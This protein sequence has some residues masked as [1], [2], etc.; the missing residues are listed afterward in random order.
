[1]SPKRKKSEEVLGKGR[2]CTINKHHK[3]NKYLGV[4]LSKD[5]DQG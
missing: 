4:E 3:Q 5:F 1:M 2:K